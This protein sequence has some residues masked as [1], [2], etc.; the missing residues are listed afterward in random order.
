MKP[1]GRQFEGESHSSEFVF[2]EFKDE[3][4]PSDFSMNLYFESFSNMVLLGMW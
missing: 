4:D 1:T 3:N 2:I